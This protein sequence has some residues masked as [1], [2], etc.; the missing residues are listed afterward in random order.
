MADQNTPISQRPSWDEY[1]IE[2]MRATG[3][4]SNCGRGRS[5]AIVVKDKRVISTGYVGAPAEL[6]TRVEVGHL[7]KTVYDERG[8]QKQHCIRTQRRTP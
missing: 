7:F 3:K 6:R 5:G 4:R 1:F 2:I 8:G